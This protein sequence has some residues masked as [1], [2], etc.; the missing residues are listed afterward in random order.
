MKLV[1]TNA[2]RRRQRYLSRERSRTPLTWF[3]EDVLSSFVLTFSLS[4]TLANLL[5]VSK[6]IRIRII[7][8]AKS[9]QRTRSREHHVESPWSVFNEVPVEIALCLGKKKNAAKFSAAVEA[10]QNH[11]ARDWLRKAGMDLEAE[12]PDGFQILSSSLTHLVIIA[13]AYSIGSKEEHFLNACIYLEH[14]LSSTR[15]HFLHFRYPATTSQPKR[16]CDEPSVPPV[17]FY[18]G[19][20]ILA[21]ISR[22][23][24][25]TT[26]IE[27]FS[28]NN[29]CWWLPKSR[30]R[31]LQK[32]G[33]T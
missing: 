13:D 33:I 3:A 8:D 24:C 20:L 31:F 17:N 27:Q 11:A 18:R 25:H 12:R 29:P 6:R 4:R 9:M 26:F 28:V 15:F 16:K 32:R 5:S 22:E 1:R 10:T 14:M 23:V 7:K 2:G 21:A 30:D 19:H